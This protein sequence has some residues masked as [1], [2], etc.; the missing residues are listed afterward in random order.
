MASLPSSSSLPSLT[1]TPTSSILPPVSVFLSQHSLEP[2]GSAYLQ[3]EMLHHSRKGTNLVCFIFHEPTQAAHDSLLSLPIA[4]LL[5]T[6]HLSVISATTQETFLVYLLYTLLVILY[7]GKFFFSWWGP[8]R[9]WPISSNSYWM[10]EICPDVS[11]PQRMN[12]IM[13]VFLWL[14]H[15]VCV[16]CV[17]WNAMKCGSSQVKQQ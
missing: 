17:E 4:K 16:K 13:L 12:E 6:S 7:I 14:Y 2:Y 9:C 1:N 15:L 11:S 10:H 8:H 3:K 5:R